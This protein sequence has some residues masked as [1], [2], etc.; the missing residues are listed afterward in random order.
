MVLEQI[1]TWIADAANLD[2]LFADLSPAC[3]DG[4]PDKERLQS[5]LVTCKKRLK[6]YIDMNLDERISD[7]E[8]REYAQPLREE[9][10]RLEAQIERCDNSEKLQT[11]WYHKV[12]KLQRAISKYTEPQTEVTPELLTL[13][14][15]IVVHER[16]KPGKAYPKPKIEVFPAL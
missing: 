2:R 3:R 13:V 10:A 1:N 12:G 16:E 8:L 5:K 9:I 6:K 11:E 14:D 7:E 4:L 15:R